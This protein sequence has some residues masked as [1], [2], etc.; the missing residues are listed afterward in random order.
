MNPDLFATMMSGAT[1]AVL[2]W[3]AGG[4][5]AGAVVFALILGIHKGVQALRYV[6]GDYQSHDDALWEADQ[7]RLRELDSIPLGG[8]RDAFGLEEYVDEY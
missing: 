2:E 1:G 3:I 5:A 7:E 4:V 8:Q 6:A